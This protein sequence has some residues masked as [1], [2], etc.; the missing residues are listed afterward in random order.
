MSFSIQEH[1]VLKFDQDVK[2]AYQQKGS[3]LRNFVEIKSGF[4][5]KSFSVNRLGIVEA[6]TKD[7]R[8][9][10][11]SHQNAEHT[12][13]WGNLVYYYNSLM[14]DPDDDDRVLANPLNK[15][16]MAGANSL[17]RKT[18]SVICAA[19]VG[20]ATSG[21]ARDG[22]AALPT[23]QKIAVG[24]GPMTIAKLTEAKRILDFNEV[25]DDGRVMAISAHALEDL[26]GTTQVTS[27]DY[28]TV[29]ALVNGQ[30]DSFLG[31]KFVRTQTTP[32][33]STTRKCIA[34]HK[35][36]IVLGITRD[37]YNRIATRNDMHD[38]KE[39]YCATDIG[40]VRRWDEGVVEISITE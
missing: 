5:G 4:A 25:P 13:R 23:A 12:V 28:N 20:T 21:E 19:A 33:S 32:L 10:M 39:T 3:R 34:W 31:F 40:A 29:K 35:D 15:Y 14:M 17:G 37:M 8:H 24:S 16:V 7:S 11:H 36:A 6:Q 27:A 2:E 38:A 1:H 30:V 9:E 26:L 22:S 18:D